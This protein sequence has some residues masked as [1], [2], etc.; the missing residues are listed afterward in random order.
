MNWQSVCFDWNRVRAF[1]VSAETGSLSAA[2]RALGIAQPTVGRQVSALEEELGVLLFERAG[3]RLILTPTG[4][5]LLEAARAMG[6]AA[7]RLS[8]AATGQATAIEGNVSITASETVAAFLLPPVLAR[9][10]QE[11]PGIEIDV[12]ASI[13]VQDLRRR[14]ADIALRNG[15][16]QGTDLV[17]RKI[18]QDGAGFYVSREWLA[19]HGPI[20]GPADLERLEIFAFDR[21]PG[22]IE[23]LKAFGVAV[24]PRQFPIMTG[25]QLV[26]WALCKQGVGAC[27]M[28]DVVGDADPAVVRI[29]PE[30]NIPVPMWLVCH[31]ELHTSRRIR[32]V[33]D[34]LAEM[35][36]S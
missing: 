31:R 8:L 25:N 3:G 34:R 24:T 33:Y 2:G 13:M 35:L 7:L 12:V 14:D 5:E 26:Q 18:R 6:E 9:L 29:L 19:T 22:M 4:V 36:A 10:R 17:A 21:G 30:V 1:L 23:A 16:P 32:L 20:E 27:V 11:H 15:R 28:M